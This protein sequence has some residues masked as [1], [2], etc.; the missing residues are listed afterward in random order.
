M[1]GFILTLNVYH[2]Y[3]FTALLFCGSARAFIRA[4][5]FRTV[6]TKAKQGKTKGI[7]IILRNNEALMPC[8]FY[9]QGQEDWAETP[10]FQLCFLSAAPH[11]AHLPGSPARSPAWLTCTVPPRPAAGGFCGQWWWCHG[12]CP[13]SRTAQSVPP[14]R[15]CTWTRL[16][17]MPSRTHYTGCLLW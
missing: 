3:F 13:G 11:P 10:V 12:V 14:W 6:L 5:P 7:K 15:L 16:S 8:S 2:S 1:W 17:H 9:I 4:R